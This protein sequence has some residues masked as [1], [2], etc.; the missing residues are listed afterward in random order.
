M[1]R[2]IMKL[3]FF[4]LSC[5]QKKSLRRDIGITFPVVTAVTTM[6]RLVIGRQYNQPQHKSQPQSSKHRNSNRQWKSVYLEI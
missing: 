4:S 6:S 2:Y 1:V 5:L 3:D